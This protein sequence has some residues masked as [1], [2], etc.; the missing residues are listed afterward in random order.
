MDRPRKLEMHCDADWAAGE[1]QMSSGANIATRAGAVVSCN[2]LYPMVI[3]SI[4]NKRMD[5][6]SVYN[7]KVKCISL[8]IEALYID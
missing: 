2:T 1:R 7:G 6:D 3:I 5:L 8:L 4:T